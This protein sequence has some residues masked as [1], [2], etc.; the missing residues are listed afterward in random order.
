MTKGD[1]TLQSENLDEKYIYEIHKLTD[2]QLEIRNIVDDTY[3]VFLR[4]NY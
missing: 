3:F 2:N 4:Q 1:S